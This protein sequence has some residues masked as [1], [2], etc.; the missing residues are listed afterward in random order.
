MT[1][2]SVVVRISIRPGFHAAV[3]LICWLAM[4]IALVSVE[5]AERFAIRAVGLLAR[6]FVKL[7]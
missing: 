7:G 2:A 3:R 5:R 6:L 4:P 1:Q